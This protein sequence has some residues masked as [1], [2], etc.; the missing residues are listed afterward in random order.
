MQSGY[1]ALFFLLVQQLWYQC[2]Q[3]LAVLLWSETD[4]SVFTLSQIMKAAPKIALPVQRKL[5]DSVGETYFNFF[6]IKNGF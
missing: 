4:I 1:I 6:K 3:N 2:E 5:E